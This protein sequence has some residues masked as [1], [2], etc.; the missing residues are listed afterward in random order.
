[1]NWQIPGFNISGHSKR[2][3][4]QA[5]QFTFFA[6]GNIIGPHL[7]FPR[8]APRYKSAIKGLLICYC[9][10]MFLQVVYMV[11]CFMH[12]KSRDAKGYHAQSTEEAREGFED[13]TDRENKHFRVSILTQC[14]TS[15]ILTAFSIAYKSEEDKLM[16][17]FP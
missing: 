12:N 17:C 10:A 8:E 14:Q 1:M 13:R 7:F 6:A 4:V 15:I 16:S 3:V 11:V 9:I 5:M 2:T